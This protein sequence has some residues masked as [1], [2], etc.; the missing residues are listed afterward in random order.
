[1]SAALLSCQMSVYLADEFRA[2]GAMPL[3]F[4][5]TSDGDRWP[6]VFGW[7][8]SLFWY[9]PVLFA[10]WMLTTWAV[11]LFLA[12]TLIAVAAWSLPIGSSINR[13]TS[14]GL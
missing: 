9:F 8:G 6:M 14:R 7:C 2:S 5:I 10:W 13:R 3:G 1:M 11:G 12:L 4:A